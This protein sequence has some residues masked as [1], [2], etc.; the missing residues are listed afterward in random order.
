MASMT[1]S[2]FTPSFLTSEIASTS[3]LIHKA[4]YFQLKIK[5]RKPLDKWHF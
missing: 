4:E 2:D 1:I 3:L 5:L